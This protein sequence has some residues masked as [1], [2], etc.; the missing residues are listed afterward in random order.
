M[1][2]TGPDGE[3]HSYI[4]PQDRERLARALTKDGQLVGEPL[5]DR[6]HWVGPRSSTGRDGQP[7]MSA[8]EDW[9]HRNGLPLD[10]PES[11]LPLREKPT[12]SANVAIRHIKNLLEEQPMNGSQRRHLCTTLLMLEKWL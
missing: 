9:A 1:A 12:L 6:G 4:A 3:T 7:A 8:A 5:P 11:T 2:L 10:P